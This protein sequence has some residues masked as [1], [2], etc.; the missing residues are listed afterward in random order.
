MRCSTAS[1]RAASVSAVSSGRTATLSCA[2]IGSRIELRHDV[3][4]RRAVLFCA[5]RER[6]CMRV[7]PL[8]GRQQR[9]MDVDQA[10]APA[11]DEPRREQAQEIPPGRRS[12]CDVLPA[13]HAP[14]GRKPRDPCRMACARPLRLRCRL[15]VRGQDR[16]RRRCSTAPARFRR[17]SQALCRPRSAP[18]CW[19]RGPRSGSRRASSCRQMAVIDDALRLCAAITSPS[20]VTVSP[21]RRKIST[22]ASA[23]SGA[24]TTTMPTPQLKV[25]SIS[26]LGNAAGRGEPAEQRRERHAREIDAHAK[27]SGNTRGMFSVNPPPVMCA[28]AFTPP[29]S[30]I[31][32]RHART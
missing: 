30:R 28:S 2:M 1:T 8:E 17:D 13:P 16:R 31:A 24:E 9:G 11:L 18:P 14:R 23:F 26:A 25:R 27:P 20:R 15:R 22:T 10:S 3:V 4:H 5:R 29:V 19:S 12:R 6:A 32:A 21:S 7:E